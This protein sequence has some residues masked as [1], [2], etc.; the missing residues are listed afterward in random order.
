MEKGT[1]RVMC[2]AQEHNTMTPARARTRIAISRV[3]RANHLAT[4]P[5]NSFLREVQFSLWFVIKDF[6][7]FYRKTCV[8]VAAGAFISYG[9]YRLLS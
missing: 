9:I 1:M 3:Q 2:V 4:A 5:P 6:F 7:Y 8:M